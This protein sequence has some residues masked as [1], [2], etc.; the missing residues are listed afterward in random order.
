[1][2]QQVHLCCDRALKTCRDNRNMLQQECCNMLRLPQHTATAMPCHA[3]PDSKTLWQASPLN[4]LGGNVTGRVHCAIAV[5]LQQSASSKTR[6][7][8]APHPAAVQAMPCRNTRDTPPLRGHALPA[9]TM[10]NPQFQHLHL[11][12]RLP[13]IP[14]LH[15]TVKNTSIERQC[16][17]AAVRCPLGVTSQ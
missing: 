6:S 16:G 11:P 5:I 10:L 14:A 9:V 4:H 17:S 1:M 13:R 15:L 12:L 7:G 2:V 3:R 8:D